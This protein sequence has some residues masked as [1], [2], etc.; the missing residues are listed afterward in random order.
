MQKIWAIA[1]NDLRIIFREKDIWLNILVIPLI[2]SFVIGFANGAGNTPSASGAVD[3][4]D[5]LIDVRDNDNS[6][7]SAQLLAE[8]RAANVNFVL[9][10]LDN[11]EADRCGLGGAAFD[12]ALVEQRLRDQ[13]TLAYIE[14]PT[15]FAQSIQDGGQMDIVYRSNEDANAPTYILQAVQ[16]AVQRV[17]TVLIAERVGGAAAASLGT[18]LSAEAQQAITADIGARAQ[19]LLQTQPTLVTEVQATIETEAPAIRPATGGFSQSIPGMGSMYVMF[20][21]FPAAVALM[22]ERKLR[23]LQRL[24]TMPVTRVQVLGGKLLARFLLGML[25]YTVIFIFGYVLGVRY[26]TD[27]IALGLTMVLFTLCI[28]ALTLALA[29]LLK[30]ENQAGAITLLLTLT[31]APLGGAWWPLEIVPDWMRTIGHIS[32]VAWA[33]NSYNELLY[34]GGNVGTVL[35]HLGVLA[36]MT[37]VCFAFGV[38]RFKVE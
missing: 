9:C 24:V 32:P 19:T 11:D 23:T 14:I 7:L 22:T 21:V 2:L 34:F 5:I 36:G 20:A 6:P 37:V 4:P 8:I 29:T 25:Q 35:P 16:A 30:N 31:L 28:T 38:A 1:Q 13:D 18:D 10:P 17:G 26:G 15:G 27:P 12:A 3:A 33:M